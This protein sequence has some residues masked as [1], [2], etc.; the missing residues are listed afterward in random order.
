LVCGGGVVDAFALFGLSDEAWVRLNRSCRR[1]SCES[2][3]LRLAGDF[4]EY[5]WARVGLL[6]V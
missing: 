5:L 2:G 4:W 1:A 3:G 6:L